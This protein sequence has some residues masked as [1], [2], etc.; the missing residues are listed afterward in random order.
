MEG[1]AA[2]WDLC[3]AT[4]KFCT[5]RLYPLRQHTPPASAALA[6]P[7]PTRAPVQPAVNHRATRALTAR[8]SFSGGAR[9]QA[10]PLLWSTGTGS[11]HPAAEEG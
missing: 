5:C 1:E 2:S 10:P 9:T 3:F 4:I 8:P 7:G 11:R 6:G